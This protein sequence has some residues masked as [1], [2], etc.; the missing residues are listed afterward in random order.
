MEAD[1][2]EGMKDVNR[3]EAGDCR[4]IMRRWIDDGVKVQSCVTSPPYYQALVIG[5]CW[6]TTIWVALSSRPR[7][8]A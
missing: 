1:K 3:C 2:E 8:G 6:P 5:I 7:A 4:A